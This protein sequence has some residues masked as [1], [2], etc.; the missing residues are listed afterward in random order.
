MPYG[1]DLY[2]KENI[3][4]YTGKIGEKPTVYF[5]REI[6]NKAGDKMIEYGRI[7]QEHNNK[8]N[9]GRAEVAQSSKYELKNETVTRKDKKVTRNKEYAMLPKKDQDPKKDKIEYEFRSFHTSR[10]P[11]IPVAPDDHK[12]KAL[13][14]N[15]LE[16]HKDIK[17]KSSK[18]YVENK[19]EEFKND[20]DFSQKLDE[21]NAKIDEMAKQSIKNQPKREKKHKKTQ[22]RLKKFVKEKRELAVKKHKREKPDLSNLGKALNSDK[23][24]IVDRVKA[25]RKNEQNIDQSSKKRV[26]SATI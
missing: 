20:K 7:T 4:A 3:F 5:K 1:D 25:K 24:E 8:F 6:T 2:K 11:H 23:K 19:V 12:T 9:V 17:P 10:N 15:A 13:L 22:K 26:R 14:A 18:I 21:L 16:A